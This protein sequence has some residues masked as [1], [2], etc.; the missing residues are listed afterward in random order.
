MFLATLTNGRWSFFTFASSH[1]SPINVIGLLIEPNIVRFQTHTFSY[2]SEAILLSCFNDWKDRFPIGI[3]Q[4]PRYWKI[5]EIT[6][7]C[8]PCTCKA[9]LRVRGH[10][11][12]WCYS[13]CAVIFALPLTRD[14]SNDTLLHLFRFPISINPTL[15]KN[16]LRNQRI[17][18]N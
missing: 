8:D 15:W 6:K 5:V 10:R 4:K 3:A 9:K 17:W 18:S 12:P 7:F 14:C 11:S 1:L 16:Y 13:I 2:L